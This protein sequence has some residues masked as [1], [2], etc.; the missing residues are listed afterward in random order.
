VK[1]FKFDLVAV[2][3]LPVVTTEKG[4]YY[5]TPTG[6]RYPSVTSVLGSQPEKKSM[7][8]KWRKRIGIEQ[9]ER[10]ST[11]AARRGTEIHSLMENYII[12]GQVPTDLMPTKKHIFNGLRNAV[13]KN[14]QT[15]RSIEAS[16]YSHR[17]KLAGRCDM[18]GE[19][20]GINSVIDYKTSA[21]MKRED[22]I[23]DYFMQC[24]AYS[25]M[26]EELTGI[27]VPNVVLL[28]GVDEE[29]EPQVFVRP[30]N[31]YVTDLF[32]VLNEYYERVA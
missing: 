27:E 24:T 14:L 12:E 10:I 8:D 32:K 11:Q 5:Q 16:L 3:N 9:A 28:I 21:K 18:I 2:E 19:W 26:F 15:I 6:E 1:Q 7:L 22:W 25:I 13:D 31:N 20:A 4:R 29:A 17:L 23:K 30:R